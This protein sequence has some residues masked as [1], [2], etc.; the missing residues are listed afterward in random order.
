MSNLPFTREELHILAVDDD[1]LQLQAVKKGLESFGYRV[2]SATNGQEALEKMKSGGSFDL[3][4]SDVMMPVMNGPQFLQEARSDSKFFETPIVMM[5]SNDQYEI[6]F[7]CLSKG[8]DD[9]IIKPL[10]AQVLK[11]IYANVWIKKKQN[12]AVAKVQHQIIE[13][14]VLQKR[15]E[16][17]K[18]NFSQTVKTPISEAMSSLEAIMTSNSVSNEVVEELSK[19]ITNLKSLNEEENVPNSDAQISPKMKDFFQSQF[20]IGQTKKAVTPIVV[21]SIRKRYAPPPA[22]F[23]THFPSL[24]LG[25]NLLSFSFNIWQINENL[26]M[27]LAHD[28]FCAVSLQQILSSKEGEIEHF[29]TKAMKGHRNN[30]FHNFR[31]AVASL[32]MMCSIFNIASR[33]FLPFEKAG[34]LFAA[35]L[36]DIDHPGT[37]NSFQIK[38]CS[39]LAMTYNDKSVLE[40]NSACVGSK[41]IQD[42][43]SFTLN[44]E[45][46]SIL[47][48]TFIRCVLRTDYSRLQKFLSRI[49][50]I[51]VDWSNK[52]HR[53]LAAMLLVIMCD[54]SFAIRQWDTAGYWYGMMRDEQLQQGDLERRIGMKPV[55]LMDRRVARSNTE[56]VKT[57]FN[58]FVIPVFQ[59][60]IKF[61]PEIEGIIMPVI[62]KNLDCILEMERIEETSK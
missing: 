18:Q 21:S 47:R 26:L 12:A 13:T 4:L 3:I 36:H 19:V 32:Q 48:Q 1:D 54:L 37:N 49:I 40:S 58:V 24:S 39:A 52:E 6:V 2:T 10:T 61:F 42:V 5:S 15:I 57:H 35:L 55:P 28:L 44:D 50:N 29:I 27:N 16:Q 38:T 62:Q 20:G 43:F 17:M 46:F 34:I 45:Q 41:L 33:P 8:A 7:D 53:Q 60:G 56:L 25:D 51:Q 31:R 23:V 22:P 11:N 59:A 14:A 9:Y 30:P